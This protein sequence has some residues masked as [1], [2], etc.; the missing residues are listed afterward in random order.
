MPTFS[1]P[2]SSARSAQITSRRSRIAFAGVDT[3]TV[4]RAPDPRFDG[5]I[6][7]EY[8]GWT[9]SSNVVVR[10]REVPACIFPFIINFGSTFRLVDPAKAADGPRK[11]G[12]FVAGMYDSFVVVES[13]GNSCCIQ[14]NFTP[15]GARLFFQLPLLEL[16]N[17]S[18]GLDE[19]YGDR[20]SG[21]VEALGNAG[22]WDR[23]FD[24]LESLIAQRISAA[25]PTRREISFA[26][27]VMRETSGRAEI[28][29]LA[30][31]L[32]WSH[33]HLIAQFRD[34]LGTTP[35]RLGR[36]LRLQRAI[37]QIGECGQPRWI[38][39][40][41][42]CGYFDQSHMIR[43]FRELAGCTPEEYS[44]LQLPHGG[45]SADLEP[46]PEKFGPR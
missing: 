32:G 35:K 34:Q 19:I 36:V 18:L 17:Q 37:Q 42:E 15:L 14:V 24:L 2:R 11:L 39:L 26:W 28:G 40:A 22:D 10:R 21:V 29:G 9:E 46:T 20:S 12:T 44:G 45:I 13:R 31:D 8:Q 16:A 30:R 7:G 5:I 3:E 4:F 38:N 1:L 43:E 25:K 23:R 41:L 33:K 6:E 27:N